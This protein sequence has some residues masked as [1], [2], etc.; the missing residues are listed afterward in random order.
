MG[1]YTE[2]LGTLTTSRP[3]TKEEITEYNDRLGEYESDMYLIFEEGSNNELRGPDCSKVVGY[4]DMEKGFMNTFNWMKSKGI[5]L[6]GRIN[7]AY[8]DIFTNDIGGGFGA[9]VVFP[10]R[11]IYYKFDFQGLK[12][13]S[14]VIY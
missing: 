11:A 4:V 13:I 1:M 14:T 3:L 6:T 2:F 8:E 5:E 7:Y 9:F 10:W 12:I